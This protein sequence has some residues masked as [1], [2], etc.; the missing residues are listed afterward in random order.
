MSPSKG[1]VENPVL[2]TSQGDPLSAFSTL[3]HRQW[4]DIRLVDGDSP[5]EGRLQVQYRSR[6]MSVC[7]NSR[8]WTLND[9]SVVCRHLG[10][11]GGNIYRWF[12]KYNHT[13]QLSLQRPNC[14]G[15]EG[16]LDACSGWDTRL[17]GSGTCEY[18]LDVGVH[19]S[20]KL[21]SE[22]ASYWKGV[23]FDRAR[24][25]RRK[26]YQNRV[27]RLISKSVLSNVVIRHAGRDRLGQALPALHV[28]RGNPPVMTNVTVEGSAFTG[29]NISNPDDF[30]V[31]Q[32]AK[33]I[34]N[35]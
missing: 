22:T 3:E 20:L 17:I 8:N 19:C 35:R 28:M 15:Q 13:E 10:F 23:H 29:V 21:G 33:F 27:D 1:T 34:N 2:L 11:G 6:W 25:S 14:T 12:E 9:L 24:A 18:H 7:T 30:F 16:R 32:D 5:N 31:I 26:R 4:P